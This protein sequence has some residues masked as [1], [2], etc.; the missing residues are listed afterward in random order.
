MDSKPF[1]PSPKKNSFRQ[2]ID[3]KVINVKLI[4]S[5]NYL[6][7]LREG[8]RGLPDNFDTDKVEEL[9]SIQ[10]ELQQQAAIQPEP[11][12]EQDCG[13]LDDTKRKQA[14]QKQ[15]TFG[16]GTVEYQNYNAI[17]PKNQRRTT[18][19]KTPDIECNVSKRKWDQIVRRWRRALHAFDNVHHENQVELARALALRL[20]NEHDPKRKAFIQQAPCFSSSLL[21]DEQ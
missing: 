1:T 16:K 12:V 6:L 5:K 3:K 4:Y 9:F 11:F 14:R 13:C 2:G 19:P 10:N 21:K 8:N 20:E 15:I 18:D 7:L 17:I